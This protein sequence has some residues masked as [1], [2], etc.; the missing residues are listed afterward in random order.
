MNLDVPAGPLATVIVL[1]WK[2]EDY[3]LPCLT[4]LAALEEADELQIIV[5]DNASGDDGAARARQ[6]AAQHGE[7]FWSLSV[8]VL[9]ENR[10]CAGGNNAG[11]AHAHPESPHLVFLNP[12]T[13]V[14]HDC[15][16]ELVRPLQDR[17]QTGI[18]GAKIYYPG[19]KTLQ[20]A[21]GFIYANAMTGHYGAGEEDEGQH[22]QPRVVGY[23]TGACFAIRRDHFQQLGG[24]DEDYFP[25]Y[26]EETDLC[27]RVQRLGLDILYVPT[28]RLY[29]HESVSMVANSP[30]FRKLYQRMRIR[31]LLK[32][33]GL[34]G[35]WCALRFELWWMLK[36][37]AA[38]GHRR[39]QI[40]AY[41]DGIRWWTR[42]KLG[43]QN[44]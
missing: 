43:L 2:S 15:I 24:L 22:D 8:V 44:R 34:R 39:E 12:D 19:T 33:L 30:G 16:R 26:F 41:L 1:L 18:T 4:S 27:A 29:H 3:V 6:F 32:N 11:A 37:P 10:G 35:L 7:T 28:A 13:E 31:Y 21:G 5:V 17:P 9:P 25:A 38:Q 42:K 23:V 20:H 36:E 14:L 40:P